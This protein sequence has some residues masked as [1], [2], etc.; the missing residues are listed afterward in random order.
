VLAII[1]AGW[2][3]LN[4]ALF[5]APRLLSVAVR[6]WEAVALLVVRLLIAGLGIA[7]GMALWQ[8]APQARVLATAALIL[9]TFAAAV[10]L[11]TSILP[12]N[13]P[14][15]DAPFWMALIALHN[16]SWLIYLWK[17]SQRA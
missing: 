4:L 6:G 8:Q 1:L 9:S 13:L 15:G 2:E 16:G 10:T 3:P 17:F 11:G 5:L 7:A 14:P 12:S